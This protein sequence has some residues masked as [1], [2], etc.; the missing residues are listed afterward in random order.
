MKHDDTHYMSLALDDAG[1]PYVGTGAEGRVYTVDDAHVVTL[2]ADTDERQVGAIGVAGLPKNVARPGT[3]GSSRRAT[4]GVPSHPRAGRRRRRLDEQGARRGRCARTSARSRGA[5]AAARALDAHGQHRD[6]R[7]DVERVEEPAH[8]ARRDREPRRALRP[9]ARALRAARRRAHRGDGPVRDRQRA[10]RGHRGRAR[11]RKAATKETKEGARA[12]GGEIAEA[13]QRREGHWKVDNPDNDPLRYRVAF[14]AK[15]DTTWRDM[16]RDGEVL[17]KTD[18]EWDTAA[19]PEGKYRVRVEASDEL[20]NPPDQVL[21]HALESERRPRRQHAARFETLA[22]TG[23]RLRARVTDGASAIARVEMAVDGEVPASGARSPQ[24]TASSTRRTRASTPT[25]RPSSRRARTSSSFARSMQ[26]ETTSCKRLPCHRP[27]SGCQG[28]G[29]WK[30]A[31]SGIY[32][33]M[34]DGHGS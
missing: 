25:W 26:P 9:G 24:R 30:V 14:A 1:T 13:R 10:P 2:V 29:R 11:R 33:M 17:T 12:S 21:K 7:R 4:R 20:A 27:G 16:L 5:R 28:G 31:F 15:A 22:I 23:R 34:K 6:A 32:A 19:L 3:G 18:Y 8:R